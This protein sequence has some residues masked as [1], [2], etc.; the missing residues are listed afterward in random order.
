MDVTV[1]E[2]GVCKKKL[3]VRIPREEIDKAFDERFD[4]LQGEALV[5]GFRPGHA[6]RRLVEKRFHRAVAEEVQAKLIADGLPKALEQEKLDVLG[7]PDVDLDAIELPEEGPLEF[8]VE[9]EVRPEF[10]LPD[11]SDIP[12]EDED[13]SVSDEDV[14]EALTRFRRMH[15]TPQAVEDEG[16]A[17]QDEDYVQGDLK[18]EIDGEAVVDREDV[19]LPVAGIAVEGMALDAFPDLVK[20]AKVGGEK[21]DTL[22]LGE[23]SQRED[24]KG[25]DATVT[26]K[27]KGILR[28]VEPDDEALLEQSGYESMDAL[29]D[30]LR[31]QQEAEAAEAAERKRRDAV[32]D[33]LVEHTELELPEDLAKR[34][35]ERVLQREL[36]NLMMR[37]MPA[38]Q[39]QAR[40]EELR[41]E[42]SERATRDLKLFF[43][44]DALAK[45]EGVEATDAEVDARV[46]YIAARGG[47]REAR[48]REEM[49]QRGS[50]D[51]LRQQIVEDKVMRRLL[52]RAESD[53]EEEAEAPET[54]AAAPADADEAQ[55]DAE[56]T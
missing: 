40:E 7:D 31:R 43:I 15:A 27:V 17:V 38:D 47:R 18:I 1:E 51:S 13:V 20:G 42:T 52:E 3:T 19:R 24:L 26:V 14:E 37:G 41:S 12:V 23:T 11:T 32:Q 25:K 29:K 46:R 36:V 28:H 49:E 55:D 56:T 54:E 10:E 6:P 34:H 45:R 50:L 33:W 9:V 5:P 8:S 22:T 53:E 21:A 16:A 44:M 39:V 48:V 35:T 2:I 4:E 30:G